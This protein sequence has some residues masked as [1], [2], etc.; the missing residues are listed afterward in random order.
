MTAVLAALREAG[1]AD[2]DIGTARFS[3]APV[4]AQ[5]DR[6][7]PRIVAYR[8]TNQVDVTVRKIAQVGEVLDKLVAA[9]ATDIAGVTFTLSDPAKLLDQ[10]RAAAFA[11]ARRKAELFAKAAGAQVGRAVNISEDETARPQPF[12]MLSQASPRAGA[13]ATPI[14]P[15]EE[16]LRAQVVVSFE[17][18]Q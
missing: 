6:A 12:R 17:L 10:A 15:G 9:G 11:D 14:E 7:E 16:T 13:A 4:H 3:I 2:A 5:R 18:N 1:I 8:V